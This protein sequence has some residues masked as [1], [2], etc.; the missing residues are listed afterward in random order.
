[1]LGK[2][3]AV[4]R[5]INEYLD[6]LKST[7]DP[8]DKLRL[9]SEIVG[10]ANRLVPILL[11]WSLGVTPSLEN[12]LALLEERKKAAFLLIECFAYVLP[13]KRNVL[14][15][16]I[17]QLVASIYDCANE[18]FHYLAKDK[19]F[20]THGRIIASANLH[21]A[22]IIASDS[23]LPVNMG[24]LYLVWMHGISAPIRKAAKRYFRDHCRTLGHP[25]EEVSFAAKMRGA[26]IGTKAIVK[27]ADDHPPMTFYVKAHQ[28]YGMMGSGIPSSQRKGIDLKELFV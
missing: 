9:S 6:V 3:E 28:N 5:E 15:A 20:E 18:G 27:F 11:E 21:M 19:V 1:M 24:D 26:Q 17:Q 7:I 13:S 14:G 23:K 16:H 10:Q 4:C 8:K 22:S 25:V 12:T 2:T